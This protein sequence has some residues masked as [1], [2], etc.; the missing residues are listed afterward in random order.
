M[1]L[2]VTVTMGGVDITDSC[3]A[4]AMVTIPAVTGDVVITAKPGQREP[5]SFR[6]ETQADML[7]SVT[8][9]GNTANNLTMTH[10]TITDGVFAKTRFTMSQGIHLRHDLPWRVEWKSAGTWTDTTDGALLFAEATPMRISQ[11]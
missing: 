4:D 9:G 8:S 2:E 1:P 3:W 6:W 10:G 5:L 11:F 7:V